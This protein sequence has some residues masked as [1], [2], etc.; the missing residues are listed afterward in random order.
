MS[1]HVKNHTGGCL[2]KKITYTIS[3]DLKGVVACHCKQ[4]RLWSGHVWASTACPTD[5]L[6][7]TTG[8]EYLSWYASSDHARR[9]FCKNCGSSLFWLPTENG[10]EGDHYAIAA[11]SLNEPTKLD[12]ERHIFCKFK[13]DY[14]TIESETRQDETY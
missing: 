9:G 14:Y 5:A 11:G 13:G 12:T 1:D 4:C 6:T 10:D 7:I 3:S 2:C 8:S